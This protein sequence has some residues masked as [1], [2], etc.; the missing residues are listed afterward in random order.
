MIRYI[1]KESNLLEE[2]DAGL[3]HSAAEVYG[4]VVDQRRDAWERKI[5]PAL[6]RSSLPKLCKE[7]KFSRRTLI[8]WRT[9]KSRAHPSNLA[10]LAKVLQRM[11]L[12]T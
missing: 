8:N 9:G 12:L 3:I 7:T 11:G 5:R 4:E 2:V 10:R 1:G 6:R